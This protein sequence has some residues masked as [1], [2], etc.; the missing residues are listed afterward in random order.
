M[1]SDG[2]TFTAVTGGAIVVSDVVAVIV[3]MTAVR[4]VAP[5]PVVVARPLR[6]R[7]SIDA[8][9]GSDDAHAADDVRNCVEP[10]LKEPTSTYGMVL[11]RTRELRMWFDG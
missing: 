9:A 8:T 5:K 11:P 4:V 7:L 2:E 10:S 3:P 6:S 1:V